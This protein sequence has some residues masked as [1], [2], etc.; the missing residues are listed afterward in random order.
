[1]LSTYRNVKCLKRLNNFISIESYNA[2]IVV[3]K[4]HLVTHFNIFVKFLLCFF[5]HCLIYRHWR[6]LL[7][8]HEK[9]WHRDASQ[10]KTT[11]TPPS[12]QAVRLLLSLAVLAFTLDPSS[13]NISSL[14]SCLSHVNPVL[15]E[16]SNAVC[17]HRTRRCSQSSSY[18]YNDVLC[19]NHPRQKAWQ[20]SWV[21]V[22]AVYDC[23][24]LLFLFPHE[25]C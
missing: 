15:E 4:H 23:I 7:L 21:S 9:W 22:P 11:G 25:A 5:M 13:V 14:I 16:N 12:K 24:K 6:K 18:K 1:M 19:H 2:Y 8:P 17:F 20:P 10:W 3:L